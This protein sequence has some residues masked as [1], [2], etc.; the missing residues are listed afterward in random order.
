MLTGKNYK[1]IIFT[2]G[3][4]CEFNVLLF[5]YRERGTRGNMEFILQYLSVDLGL[6]GKLLEDM[7]AIVTDNEKLGYLMN[8]IIENEDRYRT[9]MQMVYLFKKDLLNEIEV[10]ESIISKIAETLSETTT[11]E[12]KVHVLSDLLKESISTDIVGKIVTINSQGMSW[13]DI[14]DRLV[15]YRKTFNTVVAV[16]KLIL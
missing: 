15:E 13:Y 12:Q 5:Y 2:R 8:W 11:L 7:K 16:K 3:R 10:S 14:V 4:C 6:K 1:C 9:N